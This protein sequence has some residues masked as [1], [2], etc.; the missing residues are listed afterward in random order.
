[1]YKCI[2]KNDSSTMLFLTVFQ[3][4]MMKINTFVHVSFINGVLKM[5]SSHSNRCTRQRN[6]RERFQGNKSEVGGAI[7]LTHL[8]LISSNCFTPSNRRKMMLAK[9]FAMFDVVSAA[10]TSSTTT[11]GPRE[12]VPRVETSFGKFQLRSELQFILILSIFVVGSHV[13]S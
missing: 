2:F 7:V 12:N 4:Q 6:W 3:L 10:V 5:T 13:I 1:M 8:M 11:K 9:I